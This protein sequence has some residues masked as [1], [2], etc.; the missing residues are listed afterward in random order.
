[1]WR[2]NS[3]YPQRDGVIVADQA[4][5][6]ADWVCL[7]PLPGSSPPRPTLRAEVVEGARVCANHQ[8]GPC[9][10]RADDSL[11]TRSPRHS[12]PHQRRRASASRAGA[13][14]PSPGQRPMP[15]TRRCSR[16]SARHAWR[17]RSC[18]RDVLTT[19]SRCTLHVLFGRSPPR[20]CCRR[21]PAPR[22]AALS[23]RRPPVRPLSNPSLAGQR[24]VRGVLTR[25]W[26]GACTR[27][28][29]LRRRTTA[30]RGRGAARS[31]RGDANST[32][33]NTLDVG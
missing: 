33:P 3:A 15:F 25:T 32:P 17:G 6:V 9:R 7:I 2:G 31:R 8:Y 16:R 5:L 24:V 18:P 29:A 21:P 28:P 14:L 20:S 26:P 22:R 12:V 27:R 1:M 10:K 23:R 13:L 11:P 19:R 30:G 4:L